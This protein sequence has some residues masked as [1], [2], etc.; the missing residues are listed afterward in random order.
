[1]NLSQAI[2]KA[3]SIADLNDIFV[4][5]V[6]VQLGWTNDSVTIEGYQGAVTTDFIAHC[7]LNL[8]NSETEDSKRL[9]NF[10]AEKVFMRIN[11]LL[12]NLWH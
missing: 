4:S 6:N 3:K 1:M 10:L 8:S 2:T 12:I 7:V 11:V 9:A 5:K